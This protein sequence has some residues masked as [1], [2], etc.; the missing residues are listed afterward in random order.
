M[1]HQIGSLSVSR[2]SCLGA[3]LSPYLPLSIPVHDISSM[4]G[5]KDLHC[6]KKGFFH[7]TRFVR[8][9]GSVFYTGAART[10]S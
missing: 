1:H 4:C 6:K 9:K 8:Y 2:T 5:G 7:K 3:D 10:N